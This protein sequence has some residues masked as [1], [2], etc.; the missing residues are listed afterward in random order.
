MTYTVCI[1]YVGWK[2]YEVEAEDKNTAIDK[3]FDENDID[4]RITLC[5]NCS[6]EIDSELLIDERNIYAEEN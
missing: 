4:E 2:Y 1:P 3:V 6:N 5:W